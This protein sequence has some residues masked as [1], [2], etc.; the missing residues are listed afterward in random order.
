MSKPVIGLC[1][2]L[3]RAQWSVWDQEAVILPSNY[4]AAVQRAGGIAVLLPP[5]GREAEIAGALLDIVDGVILAGGADIDPSSYGETIRHQE[6]TMTEPRRD[7]FELSV[8]RLALER[9]L[10]LLGICRGM[11]L[12]NVARGG[13]LRQ[14][15]PEEFAHHE[16][17][18]EPG[19]FDQADHDVELQPGSLVQ[20][21]AGETV[22]SA[23][24]HH[25]QGVAKLGEGLEVTGWAVVDQLPEA[26]EDP[27]RK[28]ALGV[29]W[30]PEAD[31]TSRVIER[32]VQAADRSSAPSALSA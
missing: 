6:T 31:L 15:L 20:S 30:H 8:A 14:H 18:R 17:L 16:H 11:Q 27:T 26:I 22:H 10:P 3:E 13:T 7:R 5:D 32:F 24:S 21:V 1:T 12:I 9:D 29:Q 25:H 2:A 23:K 4:I 28:F 19:T